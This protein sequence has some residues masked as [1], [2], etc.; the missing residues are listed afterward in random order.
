MQFQ[1]DVLGIAVETA[2]E[3]E[4]TALG[5]ALLAL[6]ERRAAPAGERFEPRMSRDEADSLY[7][8]WRDAIARTLA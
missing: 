2:G 1:A 8:G 7:A 5:V 4:Q 3:P 6:G